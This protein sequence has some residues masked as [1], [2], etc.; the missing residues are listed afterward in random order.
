MPPVT[1]RTAVLALVAALLLIVRAQQ[2]GPIFAFGS[3]PE[4]FPTSVTAPPA[5][6][7][8]LY[9]DRPDVRVLQLLASMNAMWAATFAAAGDDYERPRIET[10]ATPAA[11]GC[12]AGVS[13][14]AGMYCARDKQIVVDLSDHQVVRAA[15]GDQTADDLLGYVLAHEVGHH[16]QMLRGVGL[17]DTPAERLRLEL[18]AQCLAGVWGKAAGR[19][20]LPIEVFGVDAEHGSAA[21][22]QRWME[23]GRR[24]GRPADC[25]AIFEDPGIAP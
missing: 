10:R 8:V 15:G 11:E 4:S 19:G 2:P 17:A 13:G 24:A 1:V 22:Q 14:W 7:P 21:D 25:D 23:T 20:P 9:R 12:G 6:A 18:H 5:V 3:E 16:V